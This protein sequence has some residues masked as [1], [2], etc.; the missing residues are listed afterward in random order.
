MPI[1]STLRRLDQGIYVNAD[2]LL[3]DANGAPILGFTG[4][5]AGVTYLCGDYSYL[6]TVPVNGQSPGR[7]KFTTTDHGGGH[8]VV[9][10]GAGEGDVVMNPSPSDGVVQLGLSGH[11]GNRIYLQ[12]AAYPNA[13]FVTSY[14]HPLEFR[15]VA[16]NGGVSAFKRPGIQGFA[17]ANDATEAGKLKF[18]SIAPKWNDGNLDPATPDVAGAEMLEMSPSAIKAASGIPF[19]VG[20][21]TGQNTTVAL[22]DSV[23]V[24]QIL[25]FTGGLLTSIGYDTDASTYISAVISAGGTLSNSQK[26][27][28]NKFVLAR[29]SGG[30]WAD[31]DIIA[32][33]LGGTAASHAI[34]LKGSGSITWSNTPTQSANGVGFNGTTQYG[35]TGY[36]PA[37]FGGSLSLNS[38]RLVVVIPTA[39]ANGLSSGEFAG[40]VATNRISLGKNGAGTY[41]S[42]G[43]NNG[44][45]SGAA[46]SQTDERGVAIASRNASN[47]NAIYFWA[48]TAAIGASPNV[49]N[50]GAASVGVPSAQ[51]YVGCQNNGGY[52]L[53]A[54]YT[55]AGL[56]AGGG[57]SQAVAQT[58]R[59]AWAQLQTDLGR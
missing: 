8:G 58:I 54:A 51:M 14:S 38:A 31:A 11:A 18:Y 49:N 34:Y 27:A 45:G 43:L 28:I 50:D 59:D 40:V 35:N 17:V 29:K 10:L 16:Y 13:T 23:G 52:W 41:R 33:M 36:N 4:L 47:S 12:Y 22:T 56:E 55:C 2:G 44:N 7:I 3:V 24:L 6:Q 5:T 42:Q 9:V 1:S 21:A 20:G 30:T 53:G 25:N 19:A 39:S 26:A 37:T 48:Y 46:I 15:S 32:P 57:V